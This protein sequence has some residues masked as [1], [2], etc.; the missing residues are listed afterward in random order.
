MNYPLN[1][2]EVA[3]LLYLE[4]Q[5]ST[6]K[7]KE[8]VVAQMTEY[9]AKLIE[10]YDIKKDPIKFYFMDKMQ[11]IVFDFNKTDDKLISESIINEIKN[12]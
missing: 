9:Y 4:E 1:E 10:Y 5:Q 8:K 12:K 7:H 2:E 3:K 11:K 6:D